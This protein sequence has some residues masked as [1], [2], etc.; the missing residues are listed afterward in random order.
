[1]STRTVPGCQ[2]QYWEVDLRSHLYIGQRMKRVGE[3]ID[4][5]AEDQH[6][7]DRYVEIGSHMKHLNQMH[8]HSKWVRITAAVNAIGKQ[9]NNSNSKN[10]QTQVPKMW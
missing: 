4:Q 7:L 2:Q 8:R 10:S 5:L 3:L 1:M 9:S 6:T